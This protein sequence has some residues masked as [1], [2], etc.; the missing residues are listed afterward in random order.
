MSAPHDDDARS[1]YSD[2]RARIAGQA[3]DGLD[4]LVGLLTRLCRSATTQLAVAGAAVNLMSAEGSDGV[5]AASDQHSR[6]V[7]ELQFTTGEGPCH[8]A[9]RAR[10][11]VL[12]PDLLAGH[13]WPGYAS[14]ALD[15]GVRGVF[16][17]PMNVGA[18]SF[19]VM[20]VFTEKPGSLSTD[21]MTLALTYAQI[22]TEI[23]LDGDLILHGELDAGLSTALGSRAEIHQAQGMLVVDLGVKPAEALSRMRAYAF[24]HDRALIDVAHDI[25]D[26][27]DLSEYSEPEG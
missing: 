19:G 21:Q 25:I 13:S 7:E 11:P 26:G 22:A 15:S 14:A 17:F 9:F 3:A 10:R 2:A 12:T 24:A 5:A 16:C 23:L 20:D 18:I 6:E 8:E 4:G 1:M 27:F